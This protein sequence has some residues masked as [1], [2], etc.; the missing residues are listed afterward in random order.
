MLTVVEPAVRDT[1]GLERVH[2]LV[3]GHIR[4]VSPYKE[5]GVA[6]RQAPSPLYG[7]P[8]QYTAIGAG[9]HVDGGSG[10]SDR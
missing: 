8:L 5:T 10:V 6:A 4:S 7:R 3:V 9:R 2:Q 1:S